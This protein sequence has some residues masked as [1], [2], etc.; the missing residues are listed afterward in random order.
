MAWA[1][2]L[3]VSTNVENPERQYFITNGNKVKMASNTAPTQNNPG[4]FAFFEAD[5]DNAYKIYS[6]GAGKWVSYDKTSTTNNTKN[7][8]ALVD[9]Q[10][11]ANAWQVT[12]VTIKGGAKGFHIV[13]FDAGGTTSARYWNWNGGVA[14]NYGYSYDD[15]RTVGLWTDAATTDAGSGWILT[16]EVEYSLTDM[17]GNTYEWSSLGNIGVDPTLPGAAGATLLDG[18]WNGN[19]YTATI[20]FPFHVSKE[21]GVTNMTTIASAADAKKWCA[22]DNAVIMVQ[23]SGY[24]ATDND[25]L[26]AIYPQ[27]ANGAF[28][29]KIKS[30]GK[31]KWI[32]TNASGSKVDG[33]NNND[34]ADGAAG[35]VQLTDE[36]TSFDVVKSNSVVAFHY[37]VGDSNQYL[38]I[39]SKND[40]KVYLGVHTG[41]HVGSDCYFYL[42]KTVTPPAFDGE[43]T[44]ASPYLIDSADKLATLRDEVNGGEAYEGVYFKL[45]SDITLSGEW[46]PIGNGSRSSKVYTGNAFKGVFD[47]GDNTISGLTIASATGNDAAIG[48]FGV[49]DGGTVKNLN[50]EVNINVPNNNLAGGAIGMMLNGATADN[51]TVNGAIVGND[52]VGGIAGRLV[53]D[54]TIANCTN[55]ASVTSSYGGIGGIVGKAYYEDGANTATFASITNCTNKGTI[56]A[57]MYVGGIA[58]LARANVSGCVNEGAIVGGTQTGGI[59]GQLMAAGTVS[60]NENKAKVSGKSHVGGIIGDYSQSGSYTYNNVTIANNV[61]RGE[62][63]ATEQCAAILGCNNID[64]FTAMTAAGNVSHYHADGLALFGNPEDMV[65]DAT[66]KFIVPVAQVGTE[67]YYTLAEAAAFAQEGDE[68][69][70]LADETLAEALTLPAGI[71]F[72]GNG[73]QITGT[74]VAAGDITF[75]GV[76]KAGDLDFA[77]GNTVVN[78]PAGA[79]LQLNGS[80]RMSIGFGTTFNIVGTIADAKTADKATVVPSL[81]IPGASFSGAGVKFNVTNAYISVPSS[82]CSTSKSA[83]GTFDFNITNSI[84]ESAGKLAFEEQSVNAKVDFALVNSVLTT[85]GHLV[86][87]TASGEEGVVIDNS[88]V[89]KDLSRQLENCGTM[90]VKNGSVVNG[91]VATSSNAKNPGTVIV[92]NATYAVT[93]EF[94]GSDLGT[95][96]LIIKKG[97][98]VSAGSITKANITV[99]AEGMTAADEINLTANLSKLAGELSVINND[100]L[101]AKIVDGKIVLAAKPVA[102]IDEQG[103][104]TL[105]EAFAAAA[106]GQTITLLAD[107]TPALASQRAI[108]KAAVIDLGG[109]TMTLTEDDLYFG[110]TTFKNGTIVVDPSVKASTAVFWMFANQTLTFDNVKVVATGVTGTY[111]IGLEGKNSDL[112]LLNG[113]SIIIDNAENKDFI[114]IAHNGN[115]N[116]KVENSTIDVKNVGRGFLNGNVTISDSQVNLAGIS[117]AGFRINAGQTLAINGNSTVTVEGALRDGGIHLTDLSAT[118]TKAETA[119]VN[120]TVN[121]VTPAAVIGA[122]KFATLQAA[123]NAVQNGETITLTSDVTENVTL[124]EKTG[125]YYTIDGNGKKMEGT[126]TISSL[127]DTNDNRRITIKGINF[128]TTEGRDFITSTA[129]NHYPR[130]TVEGCSFTGTGKDAADCVAIR[131]KSSHSVVIKDCTGT[132]LHSFMQ[133]TAGWNLTIE[134]VKVTDSKSGLALGTV[135]GVTVK[136]SNIDVDGYGIRMDAGYN[137]NAVIESNTVSAFI[138]VVVR[139]ATVDSNITVQGTNNFTASNTDGLWLAIGT[140]EYEANGQMPTA[141]TAQVK[142][143]LTDTGL[144]AAGIYGSYYDALT[145]HVGAAQ[146]SRTVTRDIYVAT[147][148]KAV[149]EAKAINAGAVTYK[150]YGEVELTTGG[151]H[152]ILDLGKNVVIEGADATAKLTIVGGGVPDIKGVTFKNIILADEGTYLP[153]ANEFMYQNYIDCTFENVTFVDGIRLS[154]TSSIKDSKVEANTTNEYAIWL[155]A[156]EFTMTGTT[157]VGGADAYGLVK[158]DA[159]SKITITGNTFQYLGEANKEALNV[160]GAIVVAENNTFIDCVKGILP[161]DKTNYA[162]DSKTTVAT[163]ATIAGNNTV[164][165]YYAAIGAQKFESLAAAFAAAQ[166]GDEVV[167]LKAGTYAL[168]GISGKNITVT[169]AVAGV[170]FANIGAR[171]MGGAN[172]TFNNVTFT[173]AE[174]STYKGLQHSGNL[175]YNNCTF[176]GQVFLYGQSE[177]FNKCTFN[178]TSADAYNVWTYGAKEVAFNEC[179]FNSAGKSV[180]IYSEQPAVTNNVTVTKSTFKASQAVEG[181]AA[182]EMDSSLSG[183]INLT[184]DGATTATGFA[185][186]NV[187]GNSLWNNKKGNADE[188][189]NDITV[190]VGDETVLAPVYEAKIGEKGYRSFQAA[191]AAA[192]AGATVELLAD[193]E[194][195]EVILLDKSLTINGNGHKVTSSATRVF[196]VT[197]GNV[198]VTLNNVNMVSTAVRVGTNDIRGI[199]IDAGLT[200]VQLTLNNSS[201]DFTDASANDW[202]YAVNVSGNGTGHTVTVSGGTY[203]GANVINVNGAKNTVVVKDAT[204]NCLYANNDM[205][206]GACIWVLQNQGSSVEATGNTF[207][208]NNAVAFNLGTGTGLTASNNTDNTVKVVA[209]IGAEYYTSLAE[210]FAAAEDGATIKVLQNAE[211]AEAIVVNKKVVI[212]LNGKKVTSTAKK[213]F[214]VYADATIQN[215]TIEAAQR[216]VDTRKA[217]ELTLTDVTLIADM[218]TTHGNPQ[219]LTIGG[220]ENGTKVAMTNVNISAAAGYGIITFVKTELTATEST[221]GGYNALYVKPGSDNSVFNFVKSTLS[222]STVGNDVEGNSFSV[223]AVRANN[224]TVNVDAASTVTAAGNYSYAIS[225]KS[226]YQNEAATGSSV[227]V[228]GTITGNIL[229]ALNG[230]TVRVNAEYADELQAAGYATSVADGL[231]TAKA[232]VAKIGNTNYATL[233]EAIKAAKAGDTVTVFEGTYAVPSM[234]AGIT[235]VGEGNVV[236]EGTLS[237]TLENLTMKN[238]HIKGGDAQRWAYAKGNLVFENVT[239]EATSIYALHFDGITAGATLLYKD[240]TIIGWAAMSGSPASCVFDGCTIKGNGSYGLIRTYFDATIKNCTFDVANVNTTDKYQDGIHAVSGA[241]VT[242]NNCTNANG[243]MEKVVNVSGASVV[244]LDGV[245]IKNAAK[246]GDNYYLTV[247]EAINAATEGQTVTV[248]TDIVLSETVTVPAG[249]TITLDLNGKTISQEKACTA[250]YE[251]INNKGN[252]TI[253]GEGKISF[254]DTGAGDPNFGWGSYTV[255]NEGTLVVEN[256][257]I[258]HLGE[259]AAHMYCAI[260]QYSGKSTINGGTISTPNYRSARLWKGEMTVNGGNFEGQLW[261]QAVDNTSNLVINGGTFAPRGNDGSSVFVTNSTYDVALAVTGGTF[262]TKI[263]CSDASKLAGAI[264]GGSFSATAKENTAA[265]LIATGYVFGEADANGYYTIADDPATHYINNVEEFVAFRDAVNGGNDFAGVAVYLAADIDLAGIDW[266][267]NIGDDAGATFDGTFDGQGHTIKNLTSTET[268]Q[269]GDGYICTGLFGAIHGGAV[270]KNF[271]VENVNISTGDFTG[272]NVAAVVG[273]AWQAT[274]SIENVHVTGNIN[275]NAKN[276][277]GVGAILGYDYYSPAL[278]VKNCSVIGNDGS[279]ILGKS[280]VGGLVGYA[281]SKIAMNSNT[282]EN[283][284]V[285]ATA[286]VGAIAG[287]MLSGSSAADNTV[288]NVA[289]TATGELWKNSAAVVAGTITNGG[290]TVANTTVV[291]VT[292]NGAVAALV[293]GQ[294]VEKPTAPIA[295]VEAK[296]GDKYYTTLDAAL[297]TQGEATVELLVPVTVAT[298]ESRVIN[299][300]GK[301]VIGTDNATGS[302][303]LININPEAELTINGEGAIKLTATNNRGWN[304]YSSVISNQRGKLTVNGGTIEHLGGT[305]MAY[306]IDNLTNTGAQNAETV[307]NGGTIKSTYRA[308]RQFLNSTSAQNVLTVNGGTIEGAN[309]SIWMQGA[310]TNANPGALTIEAAAAIKGDVYLT[311]AAG[312]AEYPVVVAVAADALKDGAQVLTSNVPGYY[313]VANVGGVWQNVDPVAAINGKGYATLAAALT[314]AKDGE[315]ITFLA[316]I[317]EDVTINKNLTID[318]ANKTYTGKMSVT[319]NKGTV[320][321]KNVNFDGKGYNGYAVETRGVYYLTVEDCTAKNYGYGFIQNVSS[322]VLT[323]VKNVTVSDMSYG[324]KVDYA[325]EVVLEN[326]D[327][328]VSSAAILNSNYG[329]KTITIKNSKLN[330]LGTWK[331]NDTKKTTYVFEGD[332]TVGEFKTEAGLDNFKL[333]ADPA[334]TLT[335]PAGKTVTTDVEGYSVKYEDGKYF[336]KGHV[337]KIGDKG[338]AYLADALAAA[339]NGNTITF[340]ADITED[341]TVS[342]KVTIDGDGKTY[343]GKMTLK[344][345][346]TIKNVNFDGKGYNGYAVETRGANY[347]TIEDCTAK[348]YGYGFVQLAS[349]TVST[350][351]K[352]VTVSE[353]NYGVKVD[354]SNAVVLENVDITANVAAVLNSNYGEKTITIKDSKLSIYGTWTRNNTTKTNIVFCG[355][356]TVGE[357]KHDAAIDNFQLTHDATLT[358]PE[359]LIV[360]PAASE[361]PGAEYDFVTYEN[362]VYEMVCSYIDELTIVD[363]DYTEF[364]NQNAKIVGT[365]TY[366]RD[367][368]DYIDKWQPLYVPFEIPVA[369]L[370]ALGYQVAIFYDVHFEPTG[371]GGVDL[372]S[373]PDLHILKITSGTLKANYPYVIKPSSD[374][375]QLSIELTDAKLYSTA[376]SE[377]TSVES[378]STITRF[379]FAGTYTKA[380]PEGLTGDANIPCYAINKKGNFQKMGASANLPAFRVYMS[381]VAKDGSHVVLAENAAESISMRVIGEEAEDGTTIIYDVEMDETQ[382]VDYIYDLQGRRVLEPQKGNLYIINGKKVIF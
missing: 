74:I 244:V 144:D 79:S 319:S 196:R 213:A 202:A 9:S 216:C 376:K 339:Q 228:A 108:T 191:L 118:Y 162:D 199:S 116:I 166:A 379:I 53:I 114:V 265:A 57:P 290:V 3:G 123:V 68:I 322:T 158:S 139:K 70:M 315:T 20:N 304:A 214:E 145:I 31:D 51:I 34:S 35:A 300:N 171:N 19:K 270:L 316:D 375:P 185:A 87:G 334:S 99:D 39:N 363:G 220:S 105:N 100:A 291:N 167:I 195:T 206:A 261:V 122:Q 43:G 164:T 333:V 61:N 250:S 55:N 221:I 225:F 113:S 232:A 278:T 238:I 307:I 5:G 229:A 173:Y 8:A 137:N 293:G 124:T 72:N 262:E 69:V 25:W 104:A 364:E 356:N 240:C 22:T 285:T 190:K 13:P 160:K 328:N 83:S 219:P 201:V 149:A 249:K 231:A 37:K 75:A 42:V 117:K 98:T 351:V 46:A 41:T 177:T 273:F 66:N 318:G 32:Y 377:M 96:T 223:I 95:G 241:T 292:A 284:S 2:E 371:D 381:I 279:A 311:T 248:L 7:F 17:A 62:L 16:E 82:Y 283:V 226:S 107:A 347:V 135:Q 374:N 143:D 14:V 192:E 344:A 23:T 337:A 205:Y 88:Y 260:F 301:T 176:N 150:V 183:A 340:I 58:G 212:D 264:T 324:I 11:G 187:S 50:L 366:E 152:G 259:Q 169:G 208:G 56:K 269:K 297:A 266:S 343:T 170:E 189:N 119:T 15:E 65:I 30:I 341:V 251:M 90:T 317:T 130:L 224:V 161:A 365:L 246:I 353:M 360:A 298:G 203:E 175:V 52:G 1:Q 358:A 243:N 59:I 133:N 209:K 204:L 120:A 91:A 345:D 10:E 263:G 86:F 197:T 93:G 64:G 342:T 4:K 367:M 294:L 323:S 127:S 163:D 81:V 76:T 92:E 178:Q 29:F 18:A 200:G 146:N 378:G 78:I 156:G 179:T 258:E 26:W 327:I 299:L 36:G 354:Y 346:A 207:N 40:T 77:V 373:A 276:V 252:L 142:V 181:K 359:G 12:T 253:T 234:K 211:V 80:A 110:T 159:V 101:E 335:A 89:N 361:C 147:M 154:G 215:G 165:V 357:F 236:F 362:G 85:G 369:K 141:A 109:K 257:T 188:A 287:I 281:S 84:W 308:I 157:V 312:T 186:G 348:N 330:I 131:L 255:R 272:N 332:N 254:K 329:D 28:S 256:G 222:G 180:L 305:D 182:I 138:P 242:V 321:I 174:N 126:I 355:A 128:V 245:E 217:V 121:E 336:L 210:A 125:L 103:Y 247:V 67:T 44:A 349:G 380:T 198:E 268:A 310:N 153:T 218:Y 288:K 295:K 71:T 237:G 151:S 352:N 233:D 271:T 275:I 239:F 38:S 172:V 94:S 267:V 277:T 280:Y 115:G 302:F 168:T 60:G 309:K 314:A 289:L 155:D 184:I 140:S 230:N 296:I 320:T 148:D 372:N 132:G 350:T 106:E 54:G 382:D 326:V 6:I 227:T 303:A 370:T 63:A 112:N 282:I 325:T 313:V 27:F 331:R 97:A 368:S 73:K 129:T 47:G 235:I 193:V 194:A 49:V 134:N 306:A 33:N 136:G 48:L 274:G 21:G 24:D 286:S 338:Y 102:K 45:T 111:L